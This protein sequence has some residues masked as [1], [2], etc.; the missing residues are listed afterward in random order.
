MKKKTK[1][2]SDMPRLL[3]SFFISYG[4]NGAPSFSKFAKSIGVTLAELERY[5][6]RREFDRAWRECN[7]IRRDYL[8]DAALTK[9]HDPSFVKFLL[10]SEYGM[11]EK[12]KESADTAL[13]VTLDVLSDGKHEA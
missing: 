9:R 1:Y 6:S 5:R 8:I 7:E 13:T 2:K 3:Y 12:D 10:S 11:G 4:E